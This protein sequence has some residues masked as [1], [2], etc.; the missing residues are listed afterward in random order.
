VPV[1]LDGA[2][3]RTLALGVLLGLGSVAT[4]AEQPAKPKRTAAASLARMRK[5]SD[6]LFGGRTGMARGRLS[7]RL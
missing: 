1:T 5:P 3:D 2:T 6:S 4:P 7:P